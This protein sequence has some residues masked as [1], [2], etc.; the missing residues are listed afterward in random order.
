MMVCFARS[1]NHDLP[2]ALISIPS[3]T[4]FCSLLPS[5]SGVQEATRLW[6]TI[7]FLSRDVLILIVAGDFCW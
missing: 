1:L 5:S 3:P 2:S 4:N 7:L 6:L